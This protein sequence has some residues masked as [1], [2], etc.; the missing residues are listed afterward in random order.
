MA[1]L[2]KKHLSRRTFLRGTGVT[3]AL[4]LLESM[5][6]AAT[7]WAQTAAKTR[8]VRRDLLPARRDHAEVDA[9]EGRAPSSS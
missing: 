9:G 2:T 8:T 6:P 7:A 4:P 1:F 5:V 3:M